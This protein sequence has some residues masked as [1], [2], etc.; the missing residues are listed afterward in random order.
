MPSLRRTPV[1]DARSQAKTYLAALPPETRKALTGLRA[2][3]R[4]A[5]PSAVDAFSY[6]IPGFRFDGKPLVWYAGWKEHCSLYPLTA[7]M[8]GAAAAD[9][10]RYKTSKGTIRFPLAKMPSKALIGRLV[11]ARVA[12][13]RGK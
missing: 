3:I 4:A 9:L 8:R 13:I 10:A 2:A 12:E 5:A 11:K 6:G 1:P 7:G